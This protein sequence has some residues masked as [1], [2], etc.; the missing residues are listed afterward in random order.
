MP[1]KQLLHSIQTRQY[2]N[3]WCNNISQHYWCGIYLKNK[4]IK[5]AANGS[6]RSK[7]KCGSSSTIRMTKTHQVIQT[8]SLWHCN[9]NSFVSSSKGFS[10]CILLERNNALWMNFIMQPLTWALYCRANKGLTWLPCFQPHAGSSCAAEFAAA[11]R[12]TGSAAAWKSPG[13]PWTARYCQTAWE[14]NRAVIRNKHH[15]KQEAA[16]GL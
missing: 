4:H 14:K 1:C 12:G 7:L 13:S 16:S 8:R 3:E 9:L 10:G 6:F 11:P 5:A 2:R 15:E